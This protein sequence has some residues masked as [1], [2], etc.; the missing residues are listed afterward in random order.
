MKPLTKD[1]IAVSVTGLWVNASEFFRNEVLLKSFWTE[2]YRALGLVFPSEPVNGMM[3]MV[4]G[5]LFAYTIFFFS[6]KYSLLQT[7]LICWCVGFVL[8][9][10]VTWNLLVLP[11]ALLMYAIPLSLLE[12]FVGA[13]LSKKLSAGP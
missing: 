7:G 2:H 3:W 8:M 1:I 13:Y 6:Q 12:S 10:I 4:W 11:T 5:F 9:W